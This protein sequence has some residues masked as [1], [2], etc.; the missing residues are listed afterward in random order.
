MQI[1]DR[2]AHTTPWKNEYFIGDTIQ[3]LKNAQMLATTEAVRS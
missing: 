3:P 2:T 1:N